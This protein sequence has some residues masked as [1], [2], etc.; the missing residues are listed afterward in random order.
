MSEA[1]T[2]EQLGDLDRLRDIVVSDP[3]SWWPLAPAWY[4]VIAIVIL[5]A[6]VVSW[7]FWQ[8]WRAN[9]FRRAALAEVE[10]AA[11]S[12]N[13]LSVPQLAEIFKRCALTTYPRE[14]VAALSGDGWVSWLVDKYS[15]PMPELLAEAMREGLYARQQKE[16]SSEMLDYSRQ[17]ISGHRAYSPPTP[18]N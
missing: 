15:E 13:G 7:K 6:G 16:V 14:Q 4:V 5:L 10:A 12:A 1:L 9:A 3:V 2:D 11:N 17:W 18:K 8:K